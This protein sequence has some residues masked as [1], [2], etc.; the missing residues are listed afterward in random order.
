MLGLLAGLLAM[1]AAPGAG[2]TAQVPGAVQKTAMGGSAHGPGHETPHSGMQLSGSD[3]CVAVPAAAVAAAPL[4]GGG[5]WQAPVQQVGAGQTRA[6]GARTS[7]APPDL[8][9]LCVS[10]T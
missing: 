9:A 10:R 2:A 8:D 1:H 4:D 7:R 6:V 5:S 3:L